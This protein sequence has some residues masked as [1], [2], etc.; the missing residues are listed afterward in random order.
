MGKLLAILSI[1]ICLSSCSSSTEIND[2]ETKDEKTKKMVMTSSSS[3]EPS[4]DARLYGCDFTIVLNDSGDTTYWYTKDEMF[5][6]PEGYRVGFAWSALPIELQ[7]RISKMPG[8]GYH[9][10]LDSGWQLAFCEGPSCTDMEPRAESVVKWIY[11]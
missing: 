2:K 8:W 1:T 9:I 4:D 5:K 6:T 10:D 7:N 3:M 11:K